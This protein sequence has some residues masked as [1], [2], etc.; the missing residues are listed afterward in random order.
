MGLYS[1]L[2]TH[3]IQTLIAILTTSS[4]TYLRSDCNLVGDWPSVGHLA[5]SHLMISRGWVVLKGAS[6]GAGPA[7]LPDVARSV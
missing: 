3:L 4:P 7:L 6:V 1:A 5:R 2:A